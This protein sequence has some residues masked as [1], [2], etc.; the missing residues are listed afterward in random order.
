MRDLDGTDVRLLELLAEDGRRSYSDLGEAVD[1]SPPAVSDRVSRLREA[2]VIRGF[3]VAVDRSKLRSGVPL[4]VSVDVAPGEYEAVRDAVAGAEAV[5]HVFGTAGGDVVFQARLPQAEV[6]PLLDEV[7]G[8]GAV[9]DYE[10]TLLAEV[11]WS[12]SVGGTGFA[13]ECV[14]CGN[15]V[16]EEGEAARV[17]GT[18]YHFCCP[19]CEAR[20]Q[21]RYDRLEEGAD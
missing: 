8:D 21:Q 5:E 19:T 7:A 20:F 13:L 10:V 17:D 15:T 1:L 16:S 11:E 12:P 6:R 18:L 14:E 2:G 9:R 4:L 3:T